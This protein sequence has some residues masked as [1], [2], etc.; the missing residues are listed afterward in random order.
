MADLD[1][2]AF[3]SNTNTQTATTTLTFTAN[4]TFGTAT[5]DAAA[6]SG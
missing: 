2:L 5:G 4:P 3:Q 1:Q 6:V